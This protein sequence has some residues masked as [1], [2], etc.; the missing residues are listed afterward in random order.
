MNKGLEALEM[1]EM[2]VDVMCSREY[3]EAE[4]IVEKS[5]KALEILK[6]KL[7]IGY[8]ESENDK[9]CLTLGFKNNKDELF[10]FYTTFDKEKIDLLKE[11]L[12]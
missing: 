11:V 7:V 5:L 6:E 3:N 2:T 9:P 4:K 1:M 12:L 8:D 10:I